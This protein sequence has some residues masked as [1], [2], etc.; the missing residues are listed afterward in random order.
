[1]KANQFIKL[2]RNVIREEVQVAVRT[3]LRILT[4]AITQPGTI[5]ETK[6]P[7]KV[8]PTVQ[9]KVRAP[10]Q[11]AKNQLLNEIL[12]DTMAYSNSIGEFDDYPTMPMH[13]MQMSTKPA[14]ITDFE[15]RQVD[16]NSFAQTEAGAAVVNAITKDYSALMKAIDAKKGK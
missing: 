15:G 4:E 6:A 8:K 1:M 5:S 10:K 14:V 13:Q 2:L 11:Y 12:N 3:E 7:V 16:V 9:P